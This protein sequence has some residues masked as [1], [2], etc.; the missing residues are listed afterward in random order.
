[1]T[2]INFEDGNEI[3][4]NYPG[5]IVRAKNTFIDITPK[6]SM[7]RSRSCIATFGSYD[8]KDSKA[9]APLGVCA[10][11]STTCSSVS[12]DNNRGPF[13]LSVGRYDGLDSCGS[14]AKLPLGVCATPSTT[15]SSLS[16]DNNRGPFALSVG[17]YDGLDSCGSDAVD[18][19][20]FVAEQFQKYLVNTDNSGMTLMWHGLTTKYQMKPD[21]IRIIEDIDAQGV[22]YLYLPLNHWEKSSGKF[23]ISSGKCRNKGY[24]FVHFKTAANAEEFTRKLSEY[25]FES[26]RPRTTLAA[27]QGVS[28]NL[29]QLVTAPQKRTAAGAIYLPNAM[30]KFE[31]A[32]IASLRK[33]YEEMGNGK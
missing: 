30:G 14:K 4:Y 28:L 26:R 12:D 10:T 24:A 23:R 8:F 33:L 29:T 11:P 20:A 27:H 25:T 7:I 3:D 9:K 31:C 16:D 1:M 6:R 21:L 19:E 13:A 2:S 18:N 22:A 15:C 5:Y 32:T 17:R